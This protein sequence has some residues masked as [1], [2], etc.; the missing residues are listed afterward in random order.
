[1]V[2][3]SKLLFITNSQKLQLTK[4]EYQ[5]RLDI[6]TI[7]GLKVYYNLQEKTELLPAMV[8][9]K[10]ITNTQP[11]LSCIASKNKRNKSVTFTGC[12]SSISYQDVYV[13][14]GKLTSNCLPIKVF[15][16]NV[17]PI[18]VQTYQY[19][20]EDISIFKE[21]IVNFENFIY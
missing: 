3:Q 7:K 16:T 5:N 13:F 11:K 21:L 14:L 20:F 9:L 4:F 2:L 1:M 8:S 17:Q 12:Y 19:L 18:G 6:P 15:L 10:L